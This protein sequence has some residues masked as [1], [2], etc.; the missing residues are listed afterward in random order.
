MRITAFIVS[1][2]LGLFALGLLAAGGVLLWADSKTDE[3]GYLST[4]NERFATNAYALSTDNLDVDVDGADWFVDRDRFGKIRLTVTPNA[5]KPVFAGIAPTADV[6]RYLRGAGHELVRDIDFSPFRADY[7]R[8][9]G[10]RRPA[11][12]AGRRF[13]EA[14]VH[15]A[16]SQTLTWDVE[17]GDW[18][19]VVMNA[20]ASPG[21]DAD[22]KAGAQIEFLDG[23]GWG[24]LIAGLI[25]LSISA[26]LVVVGMRSR[27]RVAA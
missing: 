27:P 25:S 26:L 23:V 16:G 11:R 9:D 13:W 1:G 7:R 24:A 6:R 19:I 17:D 8:L 4:S 3:Q 20:D 22:V 10:D 15:G 5:A 18:S 2:L 21:V 12:P 14:S